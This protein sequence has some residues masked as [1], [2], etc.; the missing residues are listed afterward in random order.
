MRE[1]GTRRPVWYAWCCRVGF[2]FMV[3]DF[4]W[5][6]YACPCKRQVL[7]LQDVRV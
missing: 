5:D 6:A 3:Y 2:H 7:R 1:F 4:P